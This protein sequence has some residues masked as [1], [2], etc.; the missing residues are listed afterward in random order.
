MRAVNERGTTS[1][2]VDRRLEPVLD[3][4]GAG[5]SVFA[6]AFIDV[7]TENAGVLD[8]QELFARVREPVTANAEQTPEYGTIRFAGHDGGDFIFVRRN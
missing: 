3:A 4:G 1:Q 7:L 2:A 6:R 8:G 5:H